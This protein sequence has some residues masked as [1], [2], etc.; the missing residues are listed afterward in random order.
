MMNNYHDIYMQTLQKHITEYDYY[1]CPRDQFQYEKLFSHFTL[2]NPV[3][4]VC[5]CKERCVNIVFQFAE[6]LWY[7]SGSN[8]LDFISYYAPSIA[9][10]SADGKTLTGTAYGKRIFFFESNN[11]FLNQWDLAKKELQSHKETKRCVISIFSPKELT[12]ENN[13]D[14][15]CT[16]SLQFICREN[17]LHMITTMRA[18]DIYRGA[19]S[20]VFSF[21]FL[22]EL[23][24][25]E[26]K[27]DLGS[28]HHQVASTHLYTRDY[29]N[30]K[31]TVE[32]YNR[33]DSYSLHFPPMPQEISAHTLEI[34]LQCE[35]ALRNNIPYPKIEHKLVGV[36]KYWKDIVLLFEIY[37]EIKHNEHLQFEY[38]D[39]LNETLQYLIK[40][41]IQTKGI[42]K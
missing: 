18:N 12:H 36:D 16:L 40:N 15:S 8:S 37:R 22:H 35:E 1:N 31:K 23:M 20:D 17:K 30:A 32:G 24:A 29:S 19:L 26:M 14:V 34:L 39:L 25:R 9:R 5:Y 33:F 10:Y 42:T 38:I 41:Y 2:A 7:L 21:T 4:R 28:Y 3:E 6:A 13:I 11:K 27:F